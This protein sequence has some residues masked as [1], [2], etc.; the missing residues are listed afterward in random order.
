MPFVKALKSFRGTDDEGFVVRGSQILV[1]DERHRALARNG[2]VTAPEQKQAREPANK[3]QPDPQNKA[4]T[5]DTIRNKD[6]RST[7]PLDDP[8]AAAEKVAQAANDKVLLN[9]PAAAEKLIEA[10]RRPL[11]SAGGKTGEE[12]APSSSQVDRPPK[13]RRLRSREVEPE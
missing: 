10:S 1:D 4:I 11:P 6:V 12:S 2:L 5:H 13:Q 8:A 7:A 9:D 3:M